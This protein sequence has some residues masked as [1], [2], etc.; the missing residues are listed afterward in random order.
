MVK[1]SFKESES[2]VIKFE[3]IS[4]GGLEIVV[5]SLYGDY[6]PSS[7]KSNV[8]L[9]LEVWRFSSVNFL[10]ALTKDCQAM[11]VSIVSGALEDETYFDVLSCAVLLESWPVLSELAWSFYDDIT[12]ISVSVTGL[13]IAALAD[14]NE[15]VRSILDS[16]AE[17]FSA[18]LKALPATIKTYSLIE[19]WLEY[20]GKRSASAKELFAVFEIEDMPTEELS[21]SSSYALAAKHSTPGRLFSVIQKLASPS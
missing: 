13:D 7:L 15:K 14:E 17:H 3:D 8:Q 18:F 2:D 21:K 19:A 1:G 16:S 12:E 10:K 9:L 11:L 4:S 20:D 6:L 5:R